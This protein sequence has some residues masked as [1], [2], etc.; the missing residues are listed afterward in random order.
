[1]TVYTEPKAVLL[2]AAELIETNGHYQSDFA[3]AGRG[4][5]PKAPVCASGAINVVT[6]GT[7]SLATNERLPQLC[8][9]AKNI[10]IDHL[11][12]MPWADLIEEAKQEYLATVDPDS[13]PA[14]DGWM[15]YL[16][17]EAVDLDDLIAEWNDD[18]CAQ[19]VVAQLRA[20]AG[21]TEPT[22]GLSVAEFL[23]AR[24][25]S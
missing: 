14:D 1:M 18:T 10:L 22:P 25:A 21:W 6:G 23:T 24:T 12:L 17:P 20:A 5:D 9:A 13:Q 15:D 16:D 7:P 4:N 19:E 2:K 3:P 8:V 11:G